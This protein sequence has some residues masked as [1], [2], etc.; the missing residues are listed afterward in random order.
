MVSKTLNTAEM[1]IFNTDNLVQQP[2]LEPGQIQ[3]LPRAV[4]GGVQ[5]A[6]AAHH[7]RVAAALR[8]A[9][10]HELAAEVPQAHPA[11]GLQQ[12]AQVSARLYRR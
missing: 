4:A 12:A 3:P 11:P 8:P 6:P 2:M 10:R 5:R 1:Y 9:Q 7:R